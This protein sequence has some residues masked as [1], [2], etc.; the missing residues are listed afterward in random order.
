MAESRNSEYILYC[1]FGTP[2]YLIRRDLFGRRNP[3]VIGSLQ[4]RVRR[5]N[6]LFQMVL[7]S[8]HT[9]DVALRP[10][11]CTPIGRIAD[12]GPELKSG[13]WKCIVA[14]ILMG[15]RHTV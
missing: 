13:E 8:D 14:L 1:E 6:T 15:K 3:T 11:M 2:S 12:Q 5:R 10:M 7:S 4:V 9:C